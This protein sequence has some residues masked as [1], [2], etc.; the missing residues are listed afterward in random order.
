MLDAMSTSY[1][2]P[3][4]TRQ[5]TLTSSAGQAVFGPFDFLLFDQLDVEILVKGD[6]STS[7]TQLEEDQFTVTPATPA[8]KFPAFFTVA[9]STPRAA[10]DLVLVRGSRL[11]SRTTDVTQGGRL[12]SGALETELDRV[13]ATEQELRR[14]IDTALGT[15]PANADAILA[16]AEA[17]RDAAQGYAAEAIA[18]AAALGSQVHQY[19]TRA[20]AI[21]ASTPVSVASITIYRHTAGYPLAPA[22]YVQGAGPLQF[23]DAGGTTWHLD[24]SSGRASVQWFGAVGNNI[25]DDTAAI[26]AALTALQGT[27]ATVFFPRGTYKIS[28]ALVITGTIRLVGETRFGTSITWT[29]TTLFALNINTAQQVF[30]ERM[31]FSGPAAATTGNIITL[32]GPGPVG[33]SFSY[34]RDC[35][36]VQ[37]YNHI[38]TSSAADWTI[39]NCIFSE[40]VGYGTYVS[41][42]VLNDAG[43]SF[44]GFCTYSSS[45]ATATA[46]E[47][48]SSGGLKIENNK[49]L[50]GLY[51]YKLD[52]TSTGPSTVDLLMVGNSIENQ[53]SAAISLNRPAGALQFGSVVIDGNQIGGAGS[54][55]STSWVGIAT[56]NNAGWLSRLIISDNIIFLPVGTGSPN[57]A[58]I[59]IGSPSS[60]IVSGNQIIACPNAGGVNLGITIGAGATAGLIGVNKFDV[61]GGGTF[62]QKISNGAPASVLVVQSVPQ[63]GNAGVTCS[64]AYGSLYVGTA[65]VVFPTPFDI[66]PTVKCA[67]N[68]LVSGV[69]AWATAISKTGFTLNAVSAS[70]G[71][72][73]TVSWEA[74]GVL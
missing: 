53:I 42:V 19:D 6:A 25:A 60:F 51:G 52:L 22:L 17:A 41:D 59:S 56:D 68:S 40:Y 3:R 16:D 10:G 34:I 30:I 70:N 33:N 47:Q 72:A 27:G 14:D 58:G 45:Q 29:S 8:T 13:V 23:T 18:A 55:V 21:A 74:L 62:T 15:L 11:G 39:E 71:G 37:G 31:T 63:S 24:T 73:G 32:D 66:A 4:Q 5:A 44:I 38:V 43:D 46:I 61:Y 48:V 9:L 69:S 26:Q 12:Q 2:I 54:P 28:G 65:A 35:Q 36:F 64:T 1:P 67:P 20:Q 7:F 50:G 57:F 49:I